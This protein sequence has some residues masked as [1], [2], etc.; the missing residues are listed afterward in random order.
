MKIYHI[1]HPAHWQPGQP[2]RT[3][4][5]AR[6]G[7]IHFSRLDQVLGVANAFYTGQR[8]LILLE[9]DTDRLTSELRWEA[10]V[11]PSTP[12]AG[13]PPADALFPHLYGPLNPEAV[14]AAHPFEPGADGEFVIPSA[15]SG[16]AA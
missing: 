16:R 7:F 13:T 3:E 8:G 4:S 6:E 11:H 12:P 2:Y 1:T 10:P 5:L 9:V 14:L 15:L